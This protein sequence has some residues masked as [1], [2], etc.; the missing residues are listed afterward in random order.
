VTSLWIFDRF[1][2]SNR[3]YTEDFFKKK[4]RKNSFY[5]METTEDEEPSIVSIKNLQKTYSNDVF[6]LRGVSIELK[7]G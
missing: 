1:I 4:I 3:G 6:A 2:E 5:Q 7:K